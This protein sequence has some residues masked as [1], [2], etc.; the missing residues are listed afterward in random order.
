[1][2]APIAAMLLLRNEDLQRPGA[3]PEVQGR[4]QGEDVPV[5]RHFEAVLARLDPKLRDTPGLEISRWPKPAKHGAEGQ[6][7]QGQPTR[8]LGGRKRL[9]L[10][11]AL[12][13]VVGW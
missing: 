8:G 1:V 12:L 7:Y 2:A 11:A 3:A 9:A 4:P 13:A 10:V 5:L 6:P